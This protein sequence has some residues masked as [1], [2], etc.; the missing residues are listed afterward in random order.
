[1]SANAPKTVITAK[2]A[3]IYPI[4]IQ[5]HFLSVNIPKVSKIR[6]PAAPQAGD[7]ISLIHSALMPYGNGLTAQ[8]TQMR[9]GGID[10][11]MM[12]KP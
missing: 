12:E 4:P 5:I 2:Y 1:M 3:H 7:I 8:Y 6:G 9:Y 10:V 11:R